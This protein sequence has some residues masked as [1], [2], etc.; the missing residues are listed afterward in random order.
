MAEG[1][2]C[3]DSSTPPSRQELLVM[4]ARIGGSQDLSERLQV[5]LSDENC[6]GSAMFALLLSGSH[7]IL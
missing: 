2:R 6:A 4:S 7:G 3:P 1:E 5:L